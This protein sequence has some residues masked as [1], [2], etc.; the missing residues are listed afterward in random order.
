MSKQISC[1][2]EPSGKR[3]TDGGA[4]SSGEELRSAPYKI[5][6]SDRL[7]E[8]MQQC[9][10]STQ[11][12]LASYTTSNSLQDEPV[13]FRGGTPSSRTAEATLTFRPL[14]GSPAK[15]LRALQVAFDQLLS[16]ANGSSPG[17]HQFY[18]D[19]PA[20]PLPKGLERQ[21]KLGS[22]LSLLPLAHH[23]NNFAHPVVYQDGPSSARQRRVVGHSWQFGPAAIPR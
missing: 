4:S 18:V 20:L 14:S 23:Q 9:K 8:C 12:V 7:I 17:S 10:R 13:R 11:S 6:S 15:Y 1:S 16:R 3:R 21:T 5:A 19:G 22:S 2:A